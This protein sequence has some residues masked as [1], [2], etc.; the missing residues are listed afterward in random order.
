MK[1]FLKASWWLLCSRRKRFPF[2]PCNWDIT[3][4]QWGVLVLY[5]KKPMGSD[6]C[7]I[8][9]NSIHK[10]THRRLFSS[11]SIKKKNREHKSNEIRDPKTGMFPKIHAGLSQTQKAHQHKNC[12][13]K[14]VSFSCFKDLLFY[15][16]LWLLIHL[17][18]D[19]F[20]SPWV[21][22]ACVWCAPMAV[23]TKG[24]GRLLQHSGQREEKETCRLI[25]GCIIKACD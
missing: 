7:Y 19:L 24:G 25:C 18:V 6:A 16:P 23:F 13:D 12:A 22:R 11:Y 2:T 3:Q 5:C 1:L 8:T 14:C 9:N 10:S 21:Q 20:S 15:F 4:Q 17:F